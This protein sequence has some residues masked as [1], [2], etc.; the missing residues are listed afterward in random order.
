MNWDYVLA[1]VVVVAV[2]SGVGAISGYIGVCL[3][4]PWWIS[5]ACGGAVLFTLYRGLSRL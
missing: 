1:C 3:G 2:C 4:I 5:T